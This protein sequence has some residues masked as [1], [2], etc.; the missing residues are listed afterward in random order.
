MRKQ[1]CEPSQMRCDGRGS[2]LLLLRPRETGE[3]LTGDARAR[4]PI[5]W[6]SGRTI[7]SL[8]TARFVRSLSSCA[9]DRRRARPS[10]HQTQ[11][12][13][14][15]D[16][17]APANAQHVGFQRLNH[18]RLNPKRPQSARE[19]RRVAGVIRRRHVKKPVVE[20]V[21]SAVR[22]RVARRNNHPA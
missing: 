9:V 6:H 13:Q 2:F 21:H 3:A 18:A 16:A 12:R 5:E 22:Q 4:A 15:R 14:L 1:S 8:S 11:R 19:T 17:K 10:Q 7:P 20:I